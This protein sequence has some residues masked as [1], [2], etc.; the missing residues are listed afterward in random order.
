MWTADNIY[1]L[2]QK[3]L[4]KDIISNE[5]FCNTYNMYLVD[6]FRCLKTKRFKNTKLSIQQNEIRYYKH[7]L[8]KEGLLAIKPKEDKTDYDNCCEENLFFENY[9]IEPNYLG[10]VE[11]IRELSNKKFIYKINEIQLKIIGFCLM[12]YQ[13]YK[14]PI[15]YYRCQYWGGTV[16]YE[17]AIVVDDEVNLFFEKEE[18]YYVYNANSND[19]KQTNKTVLQNAMSFLGIIMPTDYFTLH[20]GK[21]KWN[22]YL[23]N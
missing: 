2:P 7:N 20:T 23:L 19:L 17:F 14:I 4:I 5:N 12:I 13:K 9:V 22:M 11:Q 15:V 18:N 6:N 10:I 16:D 8:P 3:E 1:S 21:F